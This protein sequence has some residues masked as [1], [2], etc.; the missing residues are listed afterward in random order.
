[1]FSMMDAY[2]GY[3]QIKMDPKDVPKVSFVVCVCTYGFLSLSFGLKN[4][5]AT[6]PRMINVVFWMQIG[7]N[8]EVYVDDMLA[9]ST[10]AFAYATDLQEIFDTT[11][12]Y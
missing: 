12:K 4:V 2:Q 5:G 10:L 3:H 9:K 7:H 1:M 8:I 6:Y 11:R